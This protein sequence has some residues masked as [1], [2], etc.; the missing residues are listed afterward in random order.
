MENIY[1]PKIAFFIL[2]S[3]FKL[4]FK[5]FKIFVYE[6]HMVPKIGNFNKRKTLNMFIFDVCCDRLTGI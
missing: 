5:K 1:A 6:E 4:V 3:F 2:K